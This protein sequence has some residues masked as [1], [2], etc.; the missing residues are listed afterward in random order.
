MAYDEK[1]AAVEDYLKGAGL[2]VLD[3]KYSGLRGYADLIAVEGGTLVAVVLYVT[4]PRSLSSRE[5]M[6]R[7]FAAVDWMDA[8]GRR[9]DRVRVDAA[10]VRSE[11]TGGYVVEHRRSMA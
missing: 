7:R 6:R 8:H 10:A 1:L 4:I 9:Y 5:K 11:G 2:T 3:R